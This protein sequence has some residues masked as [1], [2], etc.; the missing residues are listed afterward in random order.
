[1]SIEKIRNIGL[2]KLVTQVYDF[3]SLTT[4]ELMCKFAQKINIIIEHFKYLDDR[5]SNSEKN[6]ELKLEYLLGQGL[7]EQVAK[8]LLELINNGTL[9]KLINETLLKDINIK[10]DNF[11]VEVNEQMETKLDK[12]G[13]ITMANIGQDVKE[14]MT[15]GSVAIVGRNTVLTETIVD[16]QVN[17]YKADFIKEDNNLL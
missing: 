11:K 10:V 13:I 12:D 1:M 7:E 16:N 8:R 3:D 4:D 6:L 2:D 9:G 17:Q 15:G 14:A 5:C